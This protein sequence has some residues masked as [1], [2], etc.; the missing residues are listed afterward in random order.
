MGMALLVPKLCAAQA[1]NRGTVKMD[2]VEYRGWM[3]NLKL[4]NG[5]VELVVTMDVG[6]RVIS[7]R[8]AKGKN[9]FKEY[10]DQLGKTGEREWMIR[11]GHRLWVAPEDPKRTYVLDNAPVSHQ[12]VSPG[13][14]RFRPGPEAT[15]GLQKELEV[16]LAPKGT[17]VTVVHRITNTARQGTDLAVWA[18]SVMAPGGVEI[19]PLPPK[20]KHPGSAKNAK[21]PADFAPNQVLALWPF[22]DLKDPRLEI[23]TQFITLSQD[24]KATGP[25]KL[26]LLH[27]VGAV[28]YLNGDTLFVK[29]V[30]YVEGGVYP[31]GGVNFETFTNEDMLEIETLGPVYRV[32]RGRV[33]EHTE[34]W[35]LLTVKDRNEAE[36]RLVLKRKTR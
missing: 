17:E 10:E 12:V 26:G 9:V 15:Y 20:G 25:T 32:N 27:K 28:G 30:P 1:G 4:S 22:T 19:I 24:P 33:A 8:L 11:G 23:G 14:V 31:D 2:K 18:L 13:V 5:D 29:H 35:E 21:S 7:Y 36:T 3:N 16:R 34:R 6:P